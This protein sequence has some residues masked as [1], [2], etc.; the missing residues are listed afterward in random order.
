MTSLYE[1][2]HRLIGLDRELHSILDMVNEHEMHEKHETTATI[3]EES[4]GAW[5]YNVDSETFVNELRKS[6][7]LDWVK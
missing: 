4:C 3:V 2:R 6:K 7:R 1:I 5:G